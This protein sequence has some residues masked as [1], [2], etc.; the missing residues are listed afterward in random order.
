MEK[1]S[2]QE[3]RL[4]LQFGPNYSLEVFSVDLEPLGPHGR[5]RGIPPARLPGLPRVQ[6]GRER[7]Q[8]RFICLPLPDTVHDKSQALRNILSPLSHGAGRH[9]LFK[10]GAGVTACGP[11]S[12]L[13][14]GKQHPEI[15]LLHQIA[16][17]LPSG[18][19]S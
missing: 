18:D 13:R 8:T 6:A 14:E 15:F 19:S 12:I 3:A 10:L 5:S 9:V 4:A 7:N 17:K 11:W 1:G 2:S 16:Q